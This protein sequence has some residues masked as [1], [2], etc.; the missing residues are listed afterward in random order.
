MEVLESEEI[1]ILHK[2]LGKVTVIRCHLSKDIKE[3]RERAT[4]ICGGAAEGLK[5]QKMARS[6]KMR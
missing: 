3:M 5:V 4:G 6:A 1:A 2:Q